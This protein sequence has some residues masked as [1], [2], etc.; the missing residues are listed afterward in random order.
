MEE[1]YYTY[2]TI[3]SLS[4]PAVD[5]VV[6][7]M[8]RAY[9]H[10]P[11]VPLVVHWQ[12][13]SA[14]SSLHQITDVAGHEMLRAVV[15]LQPEDDRAV[16]VVNLQ[17]KNDRTASTL[18]GLH[19]RIYQLV[20]HHRATLRQLKQQGVPVL[21]APSAVPSPPPPPLPG[22]EARQIAVLEWYRDYDPKAP[23]KEIAEYCHVRPQTIKNWRNQHEMQKRGKKE[24]P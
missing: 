20:A 10:N 23:D 5:A 4:Y 1:P 2:S 14:G 11:P 12:A 18:P 21:L 13:L 19:D 6:N 16:T 15:R 22:D 9:I 7:E 3:Y 17:T 8:L 24:V